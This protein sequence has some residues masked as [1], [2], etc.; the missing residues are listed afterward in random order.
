MRTLTR[1][2]IEQ[3]MCGATFLGGGGG[4]PLD[5]ALE[6][7]HKVAGEDFSVDLMDLKEIASEDY[8]AMVAALGSPVAMKESGNFGPDG[9]A[10]F[11][12]LQ[13]AMQT[14]QKKVAYLYSGEMGGFNTMVPMLVSIMSG[15]KTGKQVKLLD[16]DGNGRAVPE[17]N[18]SLNA[19]RGFP[20]YPVGL[21][22][23]NGNK[24]IAY[25]ISDS[26]SEQI[27]R[28]LCQL[29][30]SQI[31]FATWAMS[32]DE[33][34][35]N[36]V[37]GCITKAQQVGQA[38]AQAKAEGKDPI[39]LLKDIMECALLTHARITE[40]TVEVIQG[41]DVGITTLEDLETKE[42]FKIYF[43]NEN[44]Y[45][46][47]GDGSCVI[48]APE[49]ISLIC[50]E[51]ELAYWP[52]DNASTEVGMTVDLILCPADPKWWAADHS[53]NKVWIDALARAGYTGEQIQYKK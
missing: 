16:V 30:N 2:D 53:A 36:G 43:Q 11:E 34:L 8:G 15:K 41:F 52:L 38:I 19:A 24:M 22:S 47:R 26:E 39:C 6:I 12:A 45:I 28:A 17:L 40:K 44:L 4:G 31:G 46:K 21:G 9:V 13:T 5:I 18:T 29:Y 14:E 20:P 51:G 48:T 50:R 25:G 10:A 3:I 7:L 37:V 1:N 27:C 35:G 49:I 33:L 42:I 32:R 23:L